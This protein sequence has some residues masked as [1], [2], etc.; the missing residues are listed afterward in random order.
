LLALLPDESA[1]TN[2]GQAIRHFKSNFVRMKIVNIIL[3]LSL[4]WVYNLKLQGQPLKNNAEQ[5]LAIVEENIDKIDTINQLLVV[6]NNDISSSSAILTALEKTGKVWK[7]KFE[8]MM[9]RI[10]YNGFAAPEDKYEGDGKTPTGLYRLGQLFCY[11]KETDTQ[12]PVIQTTKDDKWIDDPESDD[13]NKYIRG[14]TKAESYE[15]LLLNSNVYKY[16]MVIEYNM[17][18][19]IKGKGSAIFFHLSE[20]PSGPTAGC[21]AI[22]ESDMKLILKW[23]HPDK[24]P[25]IYMGNSAS[26]R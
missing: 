24:N 22:K 19:V 26:F 12:M 11:E 17:H 20:N 16:C 5:A 18:P 4:L 21:V 15:N 9:A 2:E 13:Y 3:F 8:P 25:S 7:V 14:D 10:G 1:T 23:L 6:F